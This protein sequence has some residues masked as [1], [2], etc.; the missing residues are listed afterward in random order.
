MI[1]RR[2][3][4]DRDER[5]LDAGMRVFSPSAKELVIVVRNASRKHA[6]FLELSPSIPELPAELTTL[7]ADFLLRSYASA[8]R[9][10]V[11]SSTF[12]KAVRDVARALE[13]REQLIYWT[14]NRPPLRPPAFQPDDIPQLGEWEPYARRISQLVAGAC[15]DDITHLKPSSETWCNNFTCLLALYGC[16]IPPRVLISDTAEVLEG[17]RLLPPDLV[18]RVLQ[19][20]KQAGADAGWGPRDYAACFA[21]R[22]C[23]WNNQIAAAP[24]VVH[25][26]NTH[27]VHWGT[28][29]V[30]QH[31]DADFFESCHGTSD[32]RLVTLLLDLLA[33]FGWPDGKQVKIHEFRHF[34]QH[35]GYSCGIMST[36]ATLSLLTD[37]Q[38]GVKYEDL[39]AWKAFF[40]QSLLTTVVEARYKA[41]GPDRDTQLLSCS[42]PV[43]TPTPTHSCLVARS[44]S[45][46]Q[47]PPPP[48]PCMSGSLPHPVL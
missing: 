33:C 25:Q 24:F 6:R 29:R 18:A 5:L 16:G 31:G 20:G 9:Y 19:A 10:A 17:P 12:A 44:Q 46:P 28:L 14:G 1:V 27:N 7:V 34:Q 47:L 4:H 2:M 32:M 8:G 26:L 35:D 42:L 21:A 37:R 23:G 48:Q 30:W 38:L 22:H 45:K 15:V 43:Q 11:V 39:A 40:T 13:Q 41:P 3:M 36:A